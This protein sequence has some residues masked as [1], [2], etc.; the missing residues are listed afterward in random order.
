MRIFV[1]LYLKYNSSGV[2]SGGNSNLEENT[3]I[4]KAIKPVEEVMFDQFTA[5]F[6][7][8]SPLEALIAGLFEM[9]KNPNLLE[10]LDLL[11]DYEAD[12]DM[13]YQKLFID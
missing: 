9:H 5:S 12:E 4:A 2:N 11:Q 7:N 3:G 6:C 13:L 10:I 1:S 8:E